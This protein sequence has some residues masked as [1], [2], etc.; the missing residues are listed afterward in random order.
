[1]STYQVVR[2]DSA[3]KEIVWPALKTE[4][5]AR[6][7]IAWCGTDN[8]GMTRKEASRAADAAR[9]GEPYALDGYVFTITRELNQ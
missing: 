7:L 3:G 8:L 2:V 6:A 9:I 4:R 5:L 1:M